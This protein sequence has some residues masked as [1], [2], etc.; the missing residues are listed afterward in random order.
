MIN[1]NQSATFPKSSVNPHGR[2]VGQGNFTY[3]VNTQ[4]AKLDTLKNPVENCH[5]LAID[6]QGRIILVTDNTANNFIIFN[7]DGEFIDAWGTEYP[8]AH[9]I[10]VVNEN[11]EDFIYVVDS[12][13]IINKN[14][15]G[16]STEAWESPFNKVIAQ[17]GFI[18]KL[19]I[20]GK[21]IF[22]L[23]HP[24]T[25]DV[26]TP[27]MPFRPTD[28]AIA[29]NGD[30]YVTDGYGSDFVL[31]YDSQ[32]RF[33]RCWGGHENKNDNLN[34]KNTH[35]I[36]IDLRIP[37]DPHLII[38]SRAEQ[39][40]KL[41][42]MNGDYRSTIDVAGAYIGGPKFSKEHFFAPV[43]WSHIDNTNAQDSGFIS[44]FNKENK[45]IANLGGTQPKYIDGK[46]QPMQS[47]WD[48][49]QHCH[50]ICIDDE[51]NLYVGQWNSHHA[52]PYK[53]ERL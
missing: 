49:F 15:D 1:H 20:D 8:G 23:G 39:S 17:S 43:C 28:I 18:S 40:L 52:L 22:T 31:Q 21:L 6:S 37:N 11:G 46:L 36:A 33:I 3:R 27:D 2:I 50:G 47:S 24:Q 38:S 25:L 48:V 9:A 51:D 32:G 44:I 19:T 30:L 42:E 4:W 53:L 16:K 7:K 29:P 26:Y 5:D 45:V 41:F 13:W 14:W 12:G 35:G 10:K 34:L